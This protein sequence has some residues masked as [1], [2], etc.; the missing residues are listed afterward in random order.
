MIRGEDD[1]GVSRVRI[2]LEDH[3][4]KTAEADES[5]TSGCG[6]ARFQSK[7][8][9]A[10]LLQALL[11]AGCRTPSPWNLRPWQFIVVCAEDKRRQVL[12]HCVEP[13]AACTAPVVIVAVANPRVWKQAPDRL[14]ELVQ[15]GTLSA[16]TQAVHL[17]RIHRQWSVGDAGRVFAI[18]QTHAALQQ[19]SAAAAAQG[20]CTC[21]VH[22]FDAPPLARLLHVPETLVLV[23]VLAVGYCAEAAPV[24]GPSLARCVFAEAYG[25]PWGLE[26]EDTRKKSDDEGF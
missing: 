9:P 21:W 15:Q 24:P 20:L 25:L 17:S 11:E 13:G 1:K 8:V 23:G 6:V 2:F 14:A 10:D 7:A 22:E 3:A 19:I 4:A 16:G 12:R 26:P 18:A 5:V